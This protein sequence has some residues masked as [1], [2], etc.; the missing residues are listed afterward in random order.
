MG[1][2][3]DFCDKTT[4]K[5][6]ARGI[7]QQSTITQFKLTY[8]FQSVLKS[9]LDRPTSM[10]FSQDTYIYIQAPMLFCSLFKIF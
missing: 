9:N 7:W 2:S 5:G 1:F 10:D 4:E 8:V 3:Y 6:I